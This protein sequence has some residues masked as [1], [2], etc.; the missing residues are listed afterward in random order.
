MIREI[1]KTTRRFSKQELAFLSW[2]H[3]EDYKCHLRQYYGNTWQFTMSDE[4]KLEYNS[5]ESNVDW[6]SL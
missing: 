5:R 2:K 4:E 3:L 1:S 6:N